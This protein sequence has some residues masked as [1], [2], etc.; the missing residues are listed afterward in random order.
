MLNKSSPQS[1]MFFI[2][3]IVINCF[4]FASAEHNGRGGT[5]NILLN[6]S[7]VVAMHMA[8]THH[9]TVIMFD[10]TKAGPSDYR[11]EGCHHDS[12]STCWAHSVEYDIGSNSIR[13]LV[14]QSDTWCSSGAFLANGTLAQTGGHGEGSRKIRYFRPCSNGRCGWREDSESMVDER[15]YSTNQILPEKDRIFVIGGLNVFTYEFVPKSS[16]NEGAFNMPFLRET[17]NRLEEGDNLYPFVHLLPDGNLFIFANRDSILFNY[18]TNKVVKT[19]PK[20]PGDGARSYPSTGSSVMLPLTYEDGFSRAEVLVCGGSAPRA[21]QASR[22]GEL[23]EALN[24]CGRIVVTDQNPDWTMEEMPGPRVMSDMILLPTGDV[25]ILNGASHGC[26]GWDHADNPVRHPYLYKPNRI[27]GSRFSMLQ[28]SSIPRMYHS[29][30]ILI[31]DG[32]ILV[33]GSNPNR[34]YLYDVKY[35]TELRV[36]AFT[37]YYMNPFFNA[38]RAHNVTVRFD[39]RNYGVRYGE[40]FVVRFDLT[41]KPGVVE[42][43][44]YAPPFNTHSLS[45]GQRMLKLQCNSFERK[46]GGSTRALVVAPPS[47]AV[48]PAGYYLLTVV[49][50]GIPSVSKWVRFVHW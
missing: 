11:M 16:P 35:P 46:S 33:A 31:P 6:S 34:R 29:S 14:L 32:R 15:W 41:R 2:L 50:G 19:F 26:A 7:G 42:F 40:E 49:N 21:Y 17:R 5:W 47:P 43:Y 37:P 48:A 18:K 38:K 28:R 45:M 12:D 10:Q 23:H 30:A 3:F 13:P 8:V 36:E 25:L 9:N 44:V 20:I 39:H 24:T 27:N 4:Y 22:R 1:N